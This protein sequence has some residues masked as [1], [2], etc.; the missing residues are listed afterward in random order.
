MT[1]II[2]ARE[3]DMQ[4]V[5]MKVIRDYKQRIAPAGVEPYNAFVTRDD[6]HAAPQ[7]ERGL[8][9]R[10]L[11]PDS[12]GKNVFACVKHRMFSKQLNGPP[13]LILPC[14]RAAEELRIL[15][16]SQHPAKS[17]DDQLNVEWVEAARPR[18][19]AAANA[20]NPYY[21]RLP[22][23]SWRLLVRLRRLHQ[24]AAT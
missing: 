15:S 5:L 7:V 10:H 13:V 23:I 20:N 24:G 8:L 14:F 1:P 9:Q 2:A 19:E 4:V 22:D 16:N 3:E 11:P 21:G 6:I 18:E 12:D 17:S